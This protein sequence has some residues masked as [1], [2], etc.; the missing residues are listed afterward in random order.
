MPAA[1]SATPESALPLSSI[2]ANVG[3][4]EPAAGMAGLV[5]LACALRA[6]ETATCA[7]LRVVNPHVRQ[8]ARGRA[9][10][11]GRR[12]ELSTRS[13]YHGSP[14]ATRQTRTV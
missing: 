12:H 10:A 14:T 6:A 4:A 2:K 13:A 5:K 11:G 9:A 3:H 7:H 1:G 8:V